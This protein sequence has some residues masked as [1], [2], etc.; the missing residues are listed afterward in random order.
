MQLAYALVMGA[1]Q[2]SKIIPDIFAFCEKRK[3]CVRLRVVF[4]AL[5]EMTT[6]ALPP[7]SDDNPPIAINKF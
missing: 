1:P 7:E 4:R 6:I 2:L 3:C 5:G